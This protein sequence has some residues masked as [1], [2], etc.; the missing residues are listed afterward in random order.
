MNILYE[1][2]ICEE[3]NQPGEYSYRKFFE[4]EEDA[5]AFMK[6]YLEGGEEDDVEQIEINEWTSS[7]PNW[8]TLEMWCTPYG[9]LALMK[10]D[11][12]KR[13]GKGFRP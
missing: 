10:I 12:S 1:V 2:K 6:P 4:K 11:T 9:D 13:P 7:G 5:R 8:E 3:I